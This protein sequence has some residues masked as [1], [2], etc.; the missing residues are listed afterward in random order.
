MLMQDEGQNQSQTPTNWQFSPGDT[1]TPGGSSAPEQ[2]PEAAP[3]PPAPTPVNDDVPRADALPLGN[4]ETTQPAFDASQSA[5]ESVSWTASEFMTHSKSFGW[6]VI[7][8]LAVALVAVIVYFVTDSYV[9]AFTIFMAG[10][11]LGAFA[12][13]TRKPRTLNY[14]VS[15]TG[16]QIGQK[17]YPFGELKAFTIQPE[18]PINSIVLLPA[19]RFMPPITMYYD[20]KDEDRITDTLNDHLPF[21][22][23]HN[24]PVDNFMRKIR[25]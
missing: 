15:S 23:D 1:I 8:A 25:F 11:L 18:G 7:L 24:D 17:L 3:M 16:V 14:Q 12:F 20:P 22:E 4:Q 21:D 10:L 19:K 6:Y 9:S 5:H 13:M 2:R